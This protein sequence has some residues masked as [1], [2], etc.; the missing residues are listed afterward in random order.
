MFH[1][2]ILGRPTI[3]V[4]YNNF[5]S[6]CTRAHTHVH[7]QPTLFYMNENFWCRNELIT[8]SN[9]GV[10]PVLDTRTDPNGDYNRST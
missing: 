7:T 10:V 9:I 4:Y 2:Q 6:T 5:V 1:C 8:G 3:G